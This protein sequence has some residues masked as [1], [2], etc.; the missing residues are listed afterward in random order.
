MTQLEAGAKA[1]A[2]SLSN[3]DGKSVSLA[4][5]KGKKLILYF[6]PAA[7]TPACTKEA[8]D[9]RDS[10]AVFAAAGYS[11]VGVSPDSVKKIDKF[12][13]S[14]SLGFE[15]LSDEDQAVH[16]TYGAFGE[17]SMYGR[18]YLGVMRST[19]VIDESG[20]ILSAMYNV[21]ATGHVA[22]LIKHLGL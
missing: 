2:F 14:Q 18:T 10:L 5:Y 21:R 6:Y 13:S 11:V 16:K 1:P 7:S 19:F 8:V 12:H 9:F 17:K 4:D 22:L 20:K 3:Q 15:L